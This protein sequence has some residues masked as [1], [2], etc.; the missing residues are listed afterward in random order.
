MLRARPVVRRAAR[1]VYDSYLKANRV[2]Q[3]I[4]SYEAVVRLVLGTMFDEAWVP[5]L[6]R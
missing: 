4:D 6:P 2:E 3:G 1:D 5:T